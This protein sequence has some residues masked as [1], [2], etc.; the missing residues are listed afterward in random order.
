MS[1][2]G[3]QEAFK[4]ERTKE[5]GE[6]KA[7]GWKRGKEDVIMILNLEARNGKMKKG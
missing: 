4:R 6:V 5:E 7:K 1:G 2:T 3:G